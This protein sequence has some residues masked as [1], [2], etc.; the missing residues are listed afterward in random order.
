MPSL[1]RT[2]DLTP[3]FQSLVNGRPQSFLLPKSF[4]LNDFSGP[5]E[6]PR[7]NL[8]ALGASRKGMGSHFE[9]EVDL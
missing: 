8:G 4:M 6:M 7:K 9:E 2:G 3:A 5:W 1:E